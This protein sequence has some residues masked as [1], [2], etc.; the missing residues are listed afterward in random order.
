VVVPEGSAAVAAAIRDGWFVRWAA[1]RAGA[2]VEVGP[3]A[4]GDTRIA[5]ALGPP[6]AGLRDL[7]AALPVGFDRAVPTLGG[8]PYPEADVAFAL[9]LP[10]G[11]EV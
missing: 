5:A 11:G 3:E 1:R 7:A 9:R 10:G 6:P 8:T 2:R 4:A